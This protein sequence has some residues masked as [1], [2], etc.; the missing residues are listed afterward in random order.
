V[1][2]GKPATVR[3]GRRSVEISSPGKL[4]LPA[5]G[6]TKLDLARYYAEVAPVMVPLARDRPVTIH[7]FPKGVEQPGHYIKAAPAHFPDWIERATVP[8][9]G[10]TVT[11]VLANDAA[12]LAYLAGQNCITPHIWLSRVDEVDVPDRVIF[13]LDPHGDRGGFGDVRAAAREL[14]RLLRDRG[15]APYAMVTGSQGLHVTVPIRRQ[16][17]FKDVFRW[18]KSVGE[19][20][21]ATQ[22]D[23]LTVEFLKE[24]REGRIYVDV[25]R[26]AY[27]Q[28]AVAPYAVRP[29]ANAP[30]ALPIH[31][32]ELDDDGLRPDGWTVKTVPERLA[33][34]G[35]AWRGMARHARNLPE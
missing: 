28:H 32:D 13:D 29:R 27:A 11:H 14:G 24:K 19:E 5:A 20:L 31:W 1:S 10:G 6:V 30:V 12:A 17:T 18:A 15:L 7:S 34:D 16:R 9:R 26:N 22:P 21:A 8:K 33:S 2:S 4:L 25:R 3:A 35:D 23:M